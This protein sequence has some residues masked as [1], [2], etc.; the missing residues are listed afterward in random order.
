MRHISAPVPATYPAGMNSSCRTGR[1]NTPARAPAAKER[2]ARANAA[3]AAAASRNAGG[4]M[5]A[6][7]PTKVRTDRPPRKPANTG[8]ACPA[9]AAAV[10]AY[11]GTAPAPVT[12]PSPS[13]CAPAATDASS[14]AHV[15]L[16]VSPAKTGTAAR[17]PT[18]SLTF[19]K[20]G[21]RS[22]T[23]RGSNPCARATSTATGTD[24]RR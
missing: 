13:V 14:A 2:H 5:T 8:Q 16:S 17:G 24:P 1:P 23:R 21:L 4:Q 10:A 9:I 12:V 19:Q 6:A 18:R 15:P 20:P 7:P 3:V 11:T 22:P